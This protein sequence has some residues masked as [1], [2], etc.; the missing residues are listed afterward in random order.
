[1]FWIV[2]GTGLVA[3]L[4]KATDWRL[5]HWMETQSEHPEWN[6]FALYDLIFP[7]FLF[8]AGVSMP[9]SIAHRVAAG[10]SKRSLTLQSIRRAA[11]LVLLGC[12]YNGLLTFDLENQ[13]YASVLGRIGLGW[14]GAALITIHTGLRSQVLWVAGILLGYWAALSWIPVPGVGAGDLTPG[15]TLA[16]HLD[17]LLLPGRLHRGDRD[18][19][20]LLST[21]PAVATALLGV[22]SG[23]HLRRELAERDK[24]LRMIGFGIGC[25][26]LGW[27]WSLV[28]PLN[29]NLWTSSFVLWCGGLS[30][31]LLSVFYLVIDVLGHRRWAFFFI[32]IGTNAI[33]IYLLKAFVDWWSIVT[34]ALNE[35]SIHPALLWVTVI[36]AQWALLYG[37]Y[38]KRI[39]LRV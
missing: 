8:L 10:A 31:L 25:L 24:V 4:A 12:I 14:F 21:L 11:A 15:N 30:L 38:R 39:F 6:G 2:G 27:L 26:A 5:F 34:L 28:F 16:D 18:P 20:G 36:G 1:M 9:Y 23:H 13:R 29:K 19:E 22:L 33:T 17:R 35:N 3:A 32:V 37:L 7:L